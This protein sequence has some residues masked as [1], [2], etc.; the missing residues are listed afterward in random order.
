MLH[1]YNFDNYIITAL[2][3]Y[4]IT[5]IRVVKLFFQTV[6]YLLDFHKNIRF[7]KTLNEYQEQPYP[8]EKTTFEFLDPPKWNGCNTR[9]KFME[10][11]GNIHI[12]HI[13]GTLFRNIPR[14]IIESFLRIYWEYLKGMFNEY[15]TNEYLPSG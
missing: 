5:V 11:L 3:N 13:P 10:Q 8:I 7:S 6:P 9:S 1:S 2:Q 12:F 15:F 4:K 14:N